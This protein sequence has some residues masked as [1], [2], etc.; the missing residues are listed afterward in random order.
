MR[1][2]VDVA[3]FADELQFLS[4]SPVAVFENGH[5]VEGQQATNGDGMPLWSVQTLVLR[6]GRRAEIET[7]K[8]PAPVMPDIRPTAP[9]LFDGLVAKTGFQNPA[10]D[11]CRQTVDGQQDGQG[12]ILCTAASDARQDACRTA[13]EHAC[14]T[15]CPTIRDTPRTTC[16]KPITCPSGQHRRPLLDS[17]RIWRVHGI[18]GLLRFT[19]MGVGGHACR[20]GRHLR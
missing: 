20:V 17:A 2:P 10:G 6:A 18:R 14:R 16:R 11:D 9:I 5:R 13:V 19:K 1:I 12:G 4:A 3:R 8:V 15:V 7:V